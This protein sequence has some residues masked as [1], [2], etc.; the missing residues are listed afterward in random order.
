MSGPR[1]QQNANEQPAVKGK[2]NHG[3]GQ[4][5]VEDASPLSE[6]AGVGEVAAQGGIRNGT[7]E[8]AGCR[9]WGRSSAARRD[10][11]GDASPPGSWWRLPYEVET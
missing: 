6:W 2:G 3:G 9:Q 7:V 8:S 11:R 10:S 5:V 1:A 4:E